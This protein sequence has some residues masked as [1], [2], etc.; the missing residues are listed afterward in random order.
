[1]SL[2]KK[3]LIE[4]KMSVGTVRPTNDMFYSRTPTTLTGR[5][6]EHFTVLTY[7]I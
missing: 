1:M 5:E 4:Q 2:K 6:R 3:K 7:T